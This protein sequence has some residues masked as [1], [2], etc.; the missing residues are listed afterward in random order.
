MKKGADWYNSL[1]GKKIYGRYSELADL[2]LV[3]VKIDGLGN[4]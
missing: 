4:F 1:Q 2:L 3:S